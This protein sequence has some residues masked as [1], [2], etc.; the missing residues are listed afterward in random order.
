[1]KIG[2]GTDRDLYYRRVRLLYKVMETEGYR[3]DKNNKNPSRLSRM[4]GL[5]RNGKRQYLVATNIGMSSWEEWESWVR[6]TYG[7]SIEA[8]RPVSER[9]SEFIHDDI[10]TTDNAPGFSPAY[11]ST[12]VSRELEELSNAHEEDHNRHQT[13]LNC[14]RRVYTLTKDLDVIE[15]FEAV[16]RDIGLEDEEIQGVVSWVMNT[17]GDEFREPKQEDAP[18]LEVQGMIDRFNHSAG[19]VVDAPPAVPQPERSDSRSITQEAQAVKAPSVPLPPVVLEPEPNPP[20]SVITCTF[21]NAANKFSR[22]YGH[23]V[24]YNPGLG[25]LI[26][27]RKRWQI[28]RSSRILKYAEKV[29]QMYREQASQLR[30]AKQAESFFKFAKTC[31]DYRKIDNFLEGVKS[32]L[33]IDL[34][35]L[36]ND[37]CALNFQ[38]GTV[39]L[40]DGFFGP[41]CPGN[42][43]TKLVRHNYN[44]DA[45]CST[46]TAFLERIIPDANTREFVQRA[47]GYSLT[48]DTSEQVFFVLH[49]SGAN[50]KSTFLDVLEQLMGDDYAA[51]MDPQSLMASRN[52]RNNTDMAPL[53]GTRMAVCVETGH[54]QRLDEARIKAFTGG[55]PIV[56]RFLYHDSFVYHPQFKIWLA[57]NHRPVIKDTSVGLWRRV[58][59]IP[60]NVQIPLDEQDGH[61]KDKLLAEA[62]GIM[63]WGVRGA[64][65][66]FERGLKAPAQVTGATREYQSAEDTMAQFID[67]CVVNSPCCT[68]PLGRFHEA[69]KEYSGI[70]ITAR[71]FNREFLECLERNGKVN[72]VTIHGSRNI[73]NWCLT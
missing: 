61:L 41:H 21:V 13:L 54:S 57:T 40:R 47:V 18:V 17:I 15:E 66:Y 2:A 71:T 19:A 44:P 3:V 8:P 34:D 1:V 67:A 28:D 11:I 32:K 24:R 68:T 38:N 39:A 30:D 59:L 27:N 48:G 29:G 36:D 62:E 73:Q 5:T 53:R 37:R 70:K 64:T 7:Y 65:S 6:D 45:P 60:F 26:W 33:H 58:R 69:F 4:P 52:D 35:A 72:E 55:D 63:A 56:A 9:T 16:A 14:L 42:L 51:Q 43:I 23:C 22:K 10:R 12:V 31:E 46:W 50:G 49:G 25:F 20:H